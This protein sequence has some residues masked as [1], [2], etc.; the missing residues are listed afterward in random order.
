[1][2]HKRNYLLIVTLLFLACLFVVVLPA[3]GSTAQGATVDRDQ[4]E[5]AAEAVAWLLHESLNID[6]GFGVDFGTGEPASNLPTTLDALLALSAAGDNVN[7]PHF[8]RPVS[9]VA[10]LKNN[11]TELIEYAGSTGGANGKVIMALAAANQ[12]ARKFAGHDFVTKLKGQLKSDGSYN[13]TNAYNQALSILALTAVGQPV[14]AKAVAWLEQQQAGD[15]SWSDG[16]GTAHNVDATAMSI[17]A[18]FGAGRDSGSGSLK[19]ALGF[20]ADSQLPTGGWE[21]GQGFGENANSTAL[22]VQALSAAGENFY[23]DKGEWA[24]NGRAPLTALLSWQSATGAFQADF[25]QGRQDN[26]FATV[27]ALPAATG[28]P[29]P[30]PSRSEAVR[31]AVLCLAE[32][33]DMGS[34][35]W[36]QFAG[37]GVN[38]AGTSRAVEAIDAA[39]GDPQAAA[40]TPG[41]V[42][43]VEALQD[44][45][46]A[47][48][49]SGR[50]GRVGIV[51][52]GVVAAGAPYSVSDF[53]GLNLPEI[54]DERLEA[55]GSY[56]DASFG[57]LAHAEAMLGLLVSGQEVDPLAVEFLLASQT[58]GDWGGP[59]GNGAAL[60]VL[61]R[62]GKTMPQAVSHLKAT[63]QKDGGWAYSGPSDP[64]ATSEVVQGLVQQGENPFSPIWSQVNDAVIK[65]PADLVM[66]KQQTSGCWINQ[67]GPG[68]DPFS[69]TDVIILLSQQP[70]NRIARTLLPVVVRR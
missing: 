67:F 5:A 60:N 34:G 38:A 30:L 51:A 15:G 62:L 36:E 49:E 7:A 57:I 27:Q 39:G 46:P 65:N 1:M 40:W 44:L 26:L 28:K 25:G 4:R 56:D 47:Y 61:G 23:D 22:A 9:P 45:A 3:S 66:G 10:Y 29:F 21:Y 50:G 55:D 54:I 52:Q 70:P 35:G 68:E 63:Q 20:L 32:L 12:D 69:T 18:L 6:G 48:V 37:F 19:A 11:S 41:S 53:A 8:M 59:D 17:M 13:N 2:K 42:N 58:A 16:F 14:P 33:Q 24:K 64:S 31:E 43:A